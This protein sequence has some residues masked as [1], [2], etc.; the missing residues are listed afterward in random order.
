MHAMQGPDE[1]CAAL[2]RYLNTHIPISADLGIGVADLADWGVRLTAPLEPNIN[3][4]STVFGGSIY[5]LAVLAGWSLLHER[6][7]RLGYD[8]RVVVQRS[9]VEYLHAADGDI[10]A[11]CPLPPPERWVRFDRVRERSGRARIKLGVEVHARGR[12]VALMRG[13][14]VAF[15]T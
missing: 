10:E 3:H 9:E 13:V 1:R 11:I 8:D 12:I 4:R 2:E 14:Y 5:S 7:Q 6:Q 15:A